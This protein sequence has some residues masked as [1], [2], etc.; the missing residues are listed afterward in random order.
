MN[1]QLGKAPFLNT[2]RTQPDWAQF[3]NQVLEEPASGAGPEMVYQSLDP[4]HSLPEILSQT[5]PETVL[6]ID[7][8]PAV[9][10]V[11]ETV[12]SHQGYQVFCAEGADQALT[13]WHQHKTQLNLVI[14]DI[15]LPGEISGF[16]LKSSMQA[17]RPEL[18]VILFCGYSLDMI[19]NPESLRPGENFLSKPF[20]MKDLLAIVDYALQ[21]QAC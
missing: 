21:K 10:H 11:I 18:P 1:A 19:E 5:I 9:C 3:L 16:D 17:E 8:E 6:V 15:K 13:L 14:S 2:R 7:D 12:L 20:S 4:R